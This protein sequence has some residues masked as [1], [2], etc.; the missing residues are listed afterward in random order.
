MLPAEEAFVEILRPAED[1]EEGKKKSMT[2]RY[3]L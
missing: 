1:A 3:G 2:K